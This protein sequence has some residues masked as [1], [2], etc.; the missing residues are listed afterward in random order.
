MQDQ[1]CAARK[2]Q[3][4]TKVTYFL[5]TF[6]NI[7]QAMLAAEKNKED[8]FYAALWKQ[9]EQVKAAR[10]VAETAEQIKRNQETLDVLR[11]QVAAKEAQREAAKRVVE[12][13]AETM[14]QERELRRQV[15]FSMKF[16]NK[17]TN[18]AWPWILGRR[19]Q[20]ERPGHD[21]RDLSPWT[22]TQ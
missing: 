7:F 3:I 20:K 17:A 21:S 16:T 12:L 2:H 6:A 5:T 8:D 1:V 13:E 14:Q 4:G 18:F 19:I 10:E 22:G 15:I 11:I 9:D